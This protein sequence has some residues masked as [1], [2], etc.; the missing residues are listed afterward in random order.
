[1]SLHQKM[2]H[3]KMKY[4]I[5]EFFQKL[6]CYVTMEPMI[7]FPSGQRRRPDVLAV[8]LNCTV[9][10]E[11]GG[12]DNYD[13]RM[14]DYRE[15]IKKG[16]G[17]RIFI[18]IPFRYSD[19]VTEFL[20]KKLGNLEILPITEDMLRSMLPKFEFSS[21]EFFYRLWGHRPKYYASYLASFYDIKMEI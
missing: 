15:W 13:E 10:I 12:I 21:T 5:C 16:E 6:G 11:V 3:E 1:M 19:S 4:D 18:H 14:R 17:K 2:K 8:C 9:W 20:E 7:E